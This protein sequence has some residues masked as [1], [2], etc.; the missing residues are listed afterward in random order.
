MPGLRTGV[1]G[2]WNLLQ[3]DDHRDP[4]GEPLDHGPWDVDHDAA[5][6]GQ[7]GDHQND[8][9]QDRDHHHRVW[10]MGHHN[11]GE[12]HGHGA[13]GARDLDVRATEDRCHQACYDGGHEAGG[14][15]HARTHPKGERERQGN[16]THG[17]ARQD[18]SPP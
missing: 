8:P 9:G 15:A 6:P 7:P 12:D 18:V 11:R 4:G 5:E 3:E 2:E 16:H 17:D 10:S 14:R 1:Q 13:G